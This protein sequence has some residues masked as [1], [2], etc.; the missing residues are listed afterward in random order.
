MVMMMSKLNPSKLNPKP[1]YTKPHRELAHLARE[2]ISAFRRGR[3]LKHFE[4]LVG[5]AQL[6]LQCNDK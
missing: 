2:I 4:G 5:V 6:H 1:N 3:G